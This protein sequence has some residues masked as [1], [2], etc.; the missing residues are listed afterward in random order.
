[1]KIEYTISRDEALQIAT[2]FLKRQRPSQKQKR[3]F[4]LLSLLGACAFAF[5]RPAT[6]ALGESPSPLPSFLLTLFVQIPLC[7]LLL[8]L[9]FKVLVASFGSSSERVLRKIFDDQ[10]PELWGRRVLTL[11]DG[12]ITFDTDIGSQSLLAS[13]VDEIVT[14]DHGSQHGTEPAQKTTLASH[15]V[16]KASSTIHFAARPES[17][18]AVRTELPTCTGTTSWINSPFTGGADS[19]LRRGDW[20]RAKWIGRHASCGMQWT[21]NADRLREAIPRPPRM[22]GLARRR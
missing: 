1:M 4:I 13:L 15:G 7:A 6:V 8:G 2:E 16:H 17:P 5:E 11:A 18:A 3:M 21:R 10:P 19:S 22:Q 14:T 12:S 9:L 20:G